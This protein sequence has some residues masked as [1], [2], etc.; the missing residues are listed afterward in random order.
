M[1]VE[2]TVGCNDE[3]E[4]QDEHYVMISGYNGPDYQLVPVGVTLKKG[5]FDA[6]KSD[7]VL[8]CF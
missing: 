1:Y 7:S 3:T 4:L 6:Y 8:E 2:V 5:W